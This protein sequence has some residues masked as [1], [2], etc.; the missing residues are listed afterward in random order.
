MFDA[1]KAFKYPVDILFGNADARV[2]Y[3]IVYVVAVAAAGQGDVSAGRRVFDC[4]VDED[5]Q[6]LL[7]AARLG[8]NRRFVVFHNRDFMVMIQQGH[9]V[10]HILEQL[11]RVDVG[12]VLFQRAA[13]RAG[14]EQQALDEL[15]H[16]FRFLLDGRNAFLQH[17]RVGQGRFFP[18]G[19]AGPRSR[20]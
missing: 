16:V 14:E 19:P 18:S 13:V 15:A 5:S 6:H 4:V 17:G 8:I 9:F 7:Y 1:V 20:R 12:E 11:S 3:G 10:V 2:R